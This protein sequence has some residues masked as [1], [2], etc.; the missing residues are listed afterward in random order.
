MEWKDELY[1]N[2]EKQNEAVVVV[3]KREVSCSASSVVNK[4]AHHRA[5][6]RW[7]LGTPTVCIYNNKAVTF[8]SLLSMVEQ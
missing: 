7:L 8:F 2:D 4:G 1:Q 3:R 6:G 5:A